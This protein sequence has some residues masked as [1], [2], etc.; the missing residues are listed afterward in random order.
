MVGCWIGTNRMDR[1]G[2][3]KVPD[4]AFGL[5]R[6]TRVNRTTAVGYGNPSSS[7]SSARLDPQTHTAPLPSFFSDPLRS[8]FCV[9]VEPTC[10][11]ERSSKGR[12]KYFFDF[13]SAC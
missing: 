2:M 6:K 8:R 5:D 9:N 10:L 12:A 1:N 3:A 13:I 7:L 4:R 11:S